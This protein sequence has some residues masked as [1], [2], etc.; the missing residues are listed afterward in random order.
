MMHA[1]EHAN[2]ISTE[3]KCLVCKWTHTKQK[4]SDV[5]LKH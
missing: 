1:N 3:N 2:R 4:T 5:L